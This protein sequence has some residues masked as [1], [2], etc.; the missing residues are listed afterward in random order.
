MSVA[1][2]SQPVIKSKD[3]FWEIKIA[4][5]TASQLASIHSA[6]KAKD[7]LVIMELGNAHWPRHNTQFVATEKLMEYIGVFGPD[8]PLALVLS[9]RAVFVPRTNTFA[10]RHYPI[11]L[12]AV[13]LDEAAGILYLPRD[14]YTWEQVVQEMDSDG[15]DDLGDQATVSNGRQYPFTPI[16][17]QGLSKETFASASI[18]SSAA[19]AIRSDASDSP[20]R[21]PAIVKLL[22]YA[23]KCLAYFSKAEGS[24]KTQLAHWFLKTTVGHPKVT[25]YLPLAALLQNKK[26][27]QSFVDVGAMELGALSARTTDQNEELLQNTSKLV[28]D[29]FQ[30][31]KMKELSA[32]PAAKSKKRR[33]ANA[34]KRTRSD[35]SDSDE[36]PETLDLSS[37]YDD[38][39]R[40][41]D[42][43]DAFKG[44][45]VGNQG[46][47]YY[48]DTRGDAVPGE[49]DK[50]MTKR[51]LEDPP[52]VWYVKT[53]GAQDRKILTEKAQA[54]LEKG[55]IYALENFRKEGLIDTRFLPLVIWKDHMGQELQ[56]GPEVNLKRLTAVILKVGSVLGTSA[57]MFSVLLA[58]NA[59]DVL[60]TTMRNLF[61]GEGNPTRERLLDVFFDMT[62]TFNVATM[63]GFKQSPPLGFFFN[64]L[65]RFMKSIIETGNEITR[66]FMRDH[67][68]TTVN[69]P[70]TLKQPH[71]MALELGKVLE[72]ID[73]PSVLQQRL[74][75]DECRLTRR[76]QL[77]TSE[78]R[79]YFV[80]IRVHTGEPSLT[81][82]RTVMTHNFERIFA[83]DPEPAFED[84]PII[85]LPK[86]R[87][88][89]VGV[90]RFI[91]SQK[92]HV[93][94]SLKPLIPLFPEIV[95]AAAYA[96]VL[97][98]TEYRGDWP[99]GLHAQVQAFQKANPLGDKP[100]TNTLLAHLDS[101]F[102]FLG[103]TKLARKAIGSRR[104]VVNGIFYAGLF[105]VWKRDSREPRRF[106]NIRLA[107]LK[108]ID[109]ELTV[110][111]LALGKGEEEGVTFVLADGGD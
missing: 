14:I 37:V 55:Y 76:F 11:S 5:M 97:P 1:S 48:H 7:L 32:S 90:A 33:S 92:D 20:L 107:P 17:A 84:W 40:K 67:Q 73:I 96:F 95:F 15:E 62:A 56:P 64:L 102:N 59:N 111:E 27:L 3:A 18:F 110:T 47:L 46:A 85:D 21:N 68:L 91:D 66:R 50:D 93:D 74:S 9:Q 105:S 57:T 77:V 70:R 53:M 29:L 35:D 98:L 71:K 54:A 60:D 72:T 26:E 10:W 89:I 45:W 19:E 79:L 8:A 13:R 81:Y 63:N 39:P 49:D 106:N 12:C 4:D 78:K 38:F 87:C 69:P 25:Y 61:E 83:D 86:E 109:G 6:V 51:S 108:L 30:L 80:G 36:E 65:H 82:G 99:A 16:L 41:G 2:V 88:F 24:K 31:M 104:P 44:K 103:S 43:R 52:L 23:F 34:K 75:E 94:L 58:M 28:S 100:S 22:E 101:F 42:K